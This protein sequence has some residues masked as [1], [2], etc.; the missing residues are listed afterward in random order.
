MK[1]NRIVKLL[2]S[3]TGLIILSKL[4]G[5]FKQILTAS[6][7]GATLETDL[8]NLSQDFTGNIQYLLVQ[9]LLT[10]M[11]A[12]YIHSRESGEETS[13]R[14]A[15]DV[16][17]VFTLITAG[18]VTIVLVLAPA[19][20]R[21]LAPTY[22][23]EA[24]ARLT[25]YLRMFSPVLLFFVWA[26]IFNALLH[27]NKRFIPG[28][29]LSVNQ[30]VW[31]IALVLLLHKQ[32]GV[33]VLALAFFAYAAWNAGYT[34]VL[35]RPYWSFSRGNAFKNPLIRQ[36]LK[37]MAPLLL[38][39]SLI[40]VN[41][42]VDKMLVS[43]LPSGTVTSLSYASVLSNLVCTFI[44]TFASI[45]FTYVTTNISEGKK[46][47]A[48]ALTS[49]ATILMVAVFL[50][51]SILTVVCAQDIVQIVFGRGAFGTESVR[52]CAL[53]LQ[54]YG[55]VFPVYVVREVFSR[56]LYAYQD[57]RRPMINSSI[58]IVC[59]I[60][61]SIA[62]CKPFGVMGVTVATS[63]SVGVCAVLNTLSAHRQYKELSLRPLM[64]Y[65]PNMLA[66][67]ALCC[68]VAVA[69]CRLLSG[70]GSLARFGMICLAG[71]A[72]YLIPTA[73]VLLPYVRTLVKAD[74]EKKE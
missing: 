2:F 31:M 1:Q 44:T 36:L 41:Q 39:Y 40:Y 17:K 14:F 19:I 55:L 47:A 15:F 68:G 42:I 37:M 49:Q 38:G 54:G 70:Y 60:A 6:V 8:I 72:V 4:L 51:I 66:G 62:L 7:F 61:L 57:S 9:T 48:A 26:A 50:P 65:M 43:G 74:P 33:Q 24:S 32:M 28:E 35:S 69:G 46:E 5:F 58:S 45:F 30:S 25:Y 10:A 23:A 13:K 63:V 22:D 18:V 27:A 21:L 12:V 3:I 52:A 29:M 53:A 71:F 67:A 11:V 34:A 59:N 64:K 56:Y 20:S 16:L 73:P